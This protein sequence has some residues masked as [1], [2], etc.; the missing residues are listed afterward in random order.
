MSIFIT[1]QILSSI[2]VK[3][4]FSELYHIEIIKYSVI[5]EVEILVIKVA[6]LAKE[7]FLEKTYII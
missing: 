1:L 2:I 7:I 6:F 5:I 3:N 4:L